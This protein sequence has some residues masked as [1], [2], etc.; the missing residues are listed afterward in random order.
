MSANGRSSD[1]RQ[2]A[3]PG[4]DVVVPHGM[5]ACRPHWY[6]LPV[7]LRRT[8]NA[9]YRALLAGKASTDYR[10]AL[11]EATEEWQR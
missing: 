1:G 9:T 11:V 5:L 3:K 8:I 10:A 2:C 6:A 4:C 7:D